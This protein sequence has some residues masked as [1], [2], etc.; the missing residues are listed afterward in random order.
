M[1]I[2]AIGANAL[3]SLSLP[4]R[5]PSN[6]A[7]FLP[8]PNTTSANSAGSN[9]VL[10]IS[11]VPPISFEMFINLQSLDE[12]E[13]PQLTAPSATEIFLEEAQKS[14]IERMREQILAELG[15]SEE[16]LAQLPP[17]EKRAMEDKIREMIE[18]KFRQG[19]GVD[20]AGSESNASMISVVA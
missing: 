2:G 20:Q 1:S 3:F 5:A 19:M 11:P 10:P 13:E 14:P 6:A 12:P 17:D 8:S 4:I 16:S 9:S 15:L 7:N 18:E